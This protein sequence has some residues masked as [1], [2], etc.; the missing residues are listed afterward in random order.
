M[1]AWLKLL[2]APF[3]VLNVIVGLV[4]YITLLERKF[5]AR[6]QSRIG[7]G[8]IYNLRTEVFDH[9]QRQS[10]AFFTRAQTGALI[11]RL[12]SDVLGAQR[13]FT[14]TLG[15]VVGNVITLA[16][17]AATMLAL[18]WRITVATLLLLPV[19]MLPA[20]YVGRQLQQ[21]TRE[22]TDNNAAHHSRQNIGCKKL[23][24]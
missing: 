12:N 21:L 20:R 3:V 23:D 15:G 17:V 11:S 6:M 9:V 22:Q 18:S 7:E 1:P 16:T 5:A 14:S 4:T 8:L 2:I 19:F 24:M 13:A 10:I